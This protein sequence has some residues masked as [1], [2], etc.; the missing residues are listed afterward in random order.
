[1]THGEG[2]AR[3][4]SIDMRFVG[5]S[6][7]V[8][9]AVVCPISLQAQ[10]VP[11]PTA[12]GSGFFD[13]DGTSLTLTSMTKVT[14]A[15]YGPGQMAFMVTQDPIVTSVL[16]L[17]GVNQ[18]GTS[19]AFSD[20]TATLT[21]AAGDVLLTADIVNTILSPTGADTG[22]INASQVAANLQ[23]VIVSQP[24]SGTSRFVT[25]WLN[26]TN[27]SGLGAL[28]LTLTNTNTEGGSINPLLSPA[29]G[30]ALFT[31][32]AVTPEPASM[33]L[34]LLGVLGLMKRRRG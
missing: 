32:Q 28:G 29:S 11:F 12:S 24:A 15:V 27:G 3:G 26:I 6:L 18:V 13:Y 9:L 5:V 25:D 1:M 8:L 10:T 4:L 22:T 33:S 19:Y 2:S 30:N 14:M 20:G 17:S 16:Q 31:L 7:A 34:L 21:S 23:N